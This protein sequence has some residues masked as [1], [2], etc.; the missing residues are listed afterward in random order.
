[1]TEDQIKFIRQ[2]MVKG[3]SHSDQ[4]KQAM[5]DIFNELGPLGRLTLFSLLGARLDA[6]VKE[7]DYV[8]AII[9]RAAALMIFDLTNE[10]AEAEIQK[11]ENPEVQ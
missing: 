8:T 10:M 6:A 3:A 11:T 1:M 7:K 5:K 2:Q 9:H 4:E